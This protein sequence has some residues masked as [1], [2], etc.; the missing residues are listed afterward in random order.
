MKIDITVP[1]NDVVPPK[2]IGMVLDNK[3]PYYD[4]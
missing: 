3:P 2:Q 1:F 4:R